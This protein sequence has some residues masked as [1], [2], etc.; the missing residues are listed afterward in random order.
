MRRGN[1]DGSIFKLSGKRR[2]PYAV[3]ITIGWTDE[4]K[5]KYKYIG[6]YANKREAKEALRIY[7]TNPYN[8]VEKQT[9]FEEIFER[10]KN[11]NGNMS[12]KNYKSAFNKCQNLHKRKFADI[13][14]QDLKDQLDNYSPSTQRIYKVMIGHLYNYGIEHGIVSKNL[15]NFL[16]CTKEVEKK[17][18]SIFTQEE[19][20]LLWNSIDD[21]PDADIVIILLYTGMRINELF[22]ITCDNVHLENNY[23]I[24]GLKT[25]AG[26][27]RIIPIHKDIKQLIEK[28]LANGHKYLI[29]TSKGNKVDY[30]N[31]I[32]ANGN[33]HKTTSAIGVHHTAHE[34]RHTFITQMTK[35]NT[36][37]VAL[38]RIVGH[39]TDSDITDHYTHTSIQ[40]LVEAINQLNYNCIL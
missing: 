19:I 5:Q 16:K 33:W 34:T 28:R 35:C 18:K 12:L 17:K 15:G 9:T 25:K 3:R 22:S 39:T 30:G 6:Y 31:F 4:G 20:Q 13:T 29:T 40:E 23:M 36:D 14:I 8:L 21:H 2:K 38:K 11:E 7:L 27:N 10:W 26:R 37:R 24:G 1:G 32:R